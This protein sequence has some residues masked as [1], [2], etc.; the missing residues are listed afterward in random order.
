MLQLQHSAGYTPV[1]LDFILAK[2]IKKDFLILWF[3]R[4]SREH[5]AKII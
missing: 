1:M 4:E 5:R 3:E 2:N